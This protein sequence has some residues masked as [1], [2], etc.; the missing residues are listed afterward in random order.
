MWLKIQLTLQK[1][2][3]SSHQIIHIPLPL[4]VITFHRVALPESG[5][6]SAVGSLSL[7]LKP[8]IERGSLNLIH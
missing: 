5:S 8:V 2:L 1:P 6:G 3:I 4:H 7:N